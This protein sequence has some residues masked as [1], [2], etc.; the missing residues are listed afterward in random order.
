MSG[1]AKLH[2]GDQL[3][4]IFGDRRFVVWRWETRQGAKTKVPYVAGVGRLAAT[5]DPATWRTYEEA[6]A[7]FSKGTVDGI[8]YVLT[9]RDGFGALDLDHCRDKASGALEPWASEFVAR[10]DSYTEITPSGEGVRIL[11]VACGVPDAHYQLS[12][13][14]NGQKVEVFHRATRFITISENPLDRTP[15]RLNDISAILLELQAE[16]DSKKTN[17]SANGSSGADPGDDTAELIRQVTSG[18]AYHPALIP[19]SARLIGSGMYAGAAVNF[20]RAL[21][22]QV[23]TERRDVRWLARH[24]DVPR[25]VSTAQEKFG[26]AHVQSDWPTPLN[27][28]GTALSPPELSRECLPQPLFDYVEAEADRLNADSCAIAIHVLAATSASISDAWKIKMKQHDPKWLQQARIWGC[29]IKDVGGRG[30]DML[31]AAWWPVHRRDARLRLEHGRAVEIWNARREAGG[32]QFDEADDPEPILERVITSDPTIEALTDILKNG[33]KFSKLA[34][35]VDELAGLLGGFGRYNNGQ[36]G[37]E[38]ATYLK[39]YD[40]GPEWIDRVKRGSFYVPNFSLVVD[41]NIQPRK[42][43]ELGKQLTNDGLFQR[44][45]TVHAKP[46]SWREDDDR[47]INITIGARYGDLIQGLPTLLPSMG[48]DDPSPAY[49][50]IDGQAERKRFAKFISTLKRNETLPEIV[51]ETASKWE[52]LHA[53]LTLLFHVV[54]LTAQRQDGAALEPRDLHA[55]DPRWV[56]MAAKFLTDVGLPNLLRL[57]FKTFGDAD[58]DQA[59]ARKLAG[60]ILAHRLDAISVRDI[61]RH[62]RPLRGNVKRIGLVMDGLTAAGWVREA[63]IGRHDSQVWQINPEVHVR[64]AAQA[65]AERARRAEISRLLKGEEDPS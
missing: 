16:K 5:D 32:K 38:R 35:V 39:A 14:P 29:V 46:S 12:R 8:G 36:G 57:G 40:G 45:F 50:P 56:V 52:G 64:F 33:G 4:A 22:E 49:V 31:Q 37:A 25:I 17:K 62:H 60:L 9:K 42:I 18:E 30:T 1:D 10:A 58:D 61:G 20:L 23:P 44:F 54:G 34:L 27:I 6:C 24:A 2:V 7:T 41:G 55:V 63:N 47:R 65:A 28:V 11:G 51:R 21:M 53:R 15:R 26:A 43:A 13:G 19:L 59:H 3:E 48:V